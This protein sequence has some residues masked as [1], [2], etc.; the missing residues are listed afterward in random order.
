MTPTESI[1]E[2]P[3]PWS[4][5][6]TGLIMVLKGQRLLMVVDYQTADCGPYQELLYIPGKAVFGGQK[7]YTIS[8]IYV[9]SMSSVVNG[10]RNWG[11]PKILAEF[12]RTENGARVQV[13]LEAMAGAGNKP[14]AKQVSAEFPQWVAESQSEG[15]FFKVDYEAYGPSIPISTAYIPALF[16]RLGQTTEH[17]DTFLYKPHAQGRATVAK[18]HDLQVLDTQLF[19]D[20]Q[21]KDVLMAFALSPFAMV[22]PIPEKLA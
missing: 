18:I 11:I 10:R 1:A 14:T 13:Q 21:R 15:P 19:P 5:T 9:S 4:L 12:K 22:F 6:G 16:T 8:D 7:R 20:V 3:A 17:G 2:L